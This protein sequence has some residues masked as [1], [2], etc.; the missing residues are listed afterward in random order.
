MAQGSYQTIF[1]LG[2]MSF[3]WARIVSPIVFLGLGLCLI[4]FFKKKALYFSVGLL[5]ASMASIFLILSL[6]TF[7]PGFIHLRNAYI[8]G[9]SAIAEGV[10]ESFS[11]APT[12]GPSQESFA[13]G[14]KL[15]SYNAL[16][17][18]PC[19]HNAPIHKGPIRA[20]LNVRIYFDGDCIQRID[21]LR[22]ASQK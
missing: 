5:L 9:K 22:V 19:F 20:G 7:I 1:E 14:S 11:P 6:I 21:V 8:S 10:I 3:P 18:T 16:D 2:F 13:V 15:F 17:D 4:R 12:L